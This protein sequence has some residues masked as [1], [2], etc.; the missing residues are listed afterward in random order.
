MK[1]R[2]VKEGRN[3]WINGMVGIGERNEDKWM[4]GRMK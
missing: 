1:E 3:R 4:K 2:R